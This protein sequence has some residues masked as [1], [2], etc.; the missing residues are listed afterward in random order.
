MRLR[1]IIAAAAMALGIGAP[2][3]A[4][5]SPDG[6]ITFQIAF[7][8]GGST[9]TLGR[10]LAAA[11]EEQTGWEVIVENKPGG[12]GV[13]MFSAML[14]AEPDGT[15]I[16]IGVNM[17]I[18]I[19]LARRGDSLPFTAE[20][21]DYLATVTLGPLAIATDTEAPFDDFA[22]LVAF[23]KENDGALIA[24]DAGTQ[25]M[26]LRAAMKDLGVNFRIVKHNSGAEIIQSILG[27]HVDAGFVAG[28]H[29][30]YLKS[31]DLKM[32]ATATATAHGYAPDVA[33]LKEQGFDY[34]VEPYW[35]IAGPKGMPEEVKA[36]LAK[37]LDDAINSAQ[38]REVIVNSFQSEPLNLGPDGARDMLVGGL[39]DVMGL[40]EKAQ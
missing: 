15:L 31:G 26:I 16:G 29:I 28:A 36:A 35:Y 5:W 32:L 34:V 14:S 23:A 20:S 12:G 11:M 9:D 8:A 24:I 19:N 10:A 21:F 39:D 25:E 6:P 40:I 18:L 4:D 3:G 13:A 37:A 22:G 30:P 38:A 1:S 27:G 17:P 33:S 7:G 2:A